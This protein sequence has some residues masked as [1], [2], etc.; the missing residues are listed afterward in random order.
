MGRSGSRAR[1]LKRLLARVGDV[2]PKPTFPRPKWTD[3]VHADLDGVVLDVYAK[4]GGVDGEMQMAA[5]SWDLQFGDVVVELDEE[6]HFNRYR[7]TTLDADI[8]ALVRHVDMPD[9]RHWCATKEAACLTYGRYWT[10]ASTERQFG[11]SG[12]PGDLSGGGSPRWKQRAFYDFV[13]DLAPACLSLS[14][15]RLSI[16]DEMTCGSRILS[17]GDVLVDG[18]DGSEAD[19]WAAAIADRVGGGP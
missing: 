14:V 17:V 1:A 9:Y 12:P 3:L 15:A 5:G 13:K 18:L 4:L 2:A 10:S 11:P 8:Y 7:A 19:L 6:N 16:Y